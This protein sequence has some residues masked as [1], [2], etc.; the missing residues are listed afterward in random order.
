MQGDPAPSA[1]FPSAPPPL[2]PPATAPPPPVPPDPGAVPPPG[3]NLTAGR[4]PAEVRTKFESMPVMFG[5]LAKGYASV[6][7]LLPCPPHVHLTRAEHPGAG[8]E[9]QV[10]RKGVAL[11]QYN[12]VKQVDGI[13]AGSALLAAQES[14]PQ[15][16][17]IGSCVLEADLP[18][19]AGS[20]AAVEYAAIVN[21]HFAQKINQFGGQTGVVQEHAL[22]A[23]N[24]ACAAVTEVLKDAGRV[25]QEFQE[26][27]E[28]YELDP[29][30]AVRATVHKRT[31]LLVDFEWFAFC[32]NSWGKE[33][34]RTGFSKL[35]S[36]AEQTKQ[37]H[38]FFVKLNEALRKIKPRLIQAAGDGGCITHT[39][40]AGFFEAIIFGISILERR[41]VKHAG[42]EH[43]RARL[44]GLLVPFMSGFAMSYDYGAFDS[45]NC[46]HK[47]DPRHSMKVLIENKI[48]K[49]LFGEDISDSSREALEDRC[50]EFLRSRSAYWLL[51]TKTF[52]RESGDRGTS[53]LNFLVNLILWL[54]IM[55]MESAYRETC[56]KHPAAAAQVP[57][58][59]GNKPSWI[60]A[61]VQGM[62]YD[63][64]IVRKFLRGEPCGFDLIAEGD[65]GLWLFTLKFITNSPGG[66]D[67]LAD[68]IH[69]W[70]CM[71]GMNLE[72]Q[73]E[74]GEA[75]GS[76]R[77]Q[78]VDRRME[79][80]SRIIVPYWSVV[81]EKRTGGAKSART[82]PGGVP[83]PEG[84]REVLRVGLLPKMRK[85]IEAADITFGLVG[86]TVL[87]VKTKRSIAFTKFASAAFNSLDDPFMF[88]YFMMHSRVLLLGDGK[89]P[90][91]DQYWDR[92]VQARFMY[93][94]DNYVHRNML[95][96]LGGQN[97]TR[98][99]ETAV[100]MP[101]GPLKLLQLLRGRHDRALKADGHCA[102]MER[103]VMLESP[104]IDS[105]F[106]HGSIH[107][108]QNASTWATCSEWSGLIKDRL[109]AV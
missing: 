63:D 93:S 10:A 9:S 37:R 30:D 3:S 87:D 105:D 5:T 107:V 59:D 97:E 62:E 45:A 56:K 55:G 99:E 49:E 35:P 64:T 66:A 85:T 81:D 77:V 26:F 32:P 60:N 20:G 34:G 106:Y 23:I 1:G 74:T 29:Q 17:V 42:P 8:R 52:G 79:H 2:P 48:L 92:D 94:A 70:S 69:Y 84:K 76:A 103:A 72:P 27:P 68:R 65:D 108:M 15:Y 11:E 40:D 44:A 104:L 73:D 88:E 7:T 75:V 28:G 22:P 24:G 89:S 80:C 53:C 58:S 67:G 33:R 25:A 43:L 86:G 83:L 82:R 100:Q 14:N 51:Y 4:K 91:L 50:R 36:T 101:F 19:V 6:E 96:V 90:D 13:Y 18:H 109:G 39:F 31:T 71:Q 102:A 41:S 38:T 57:A 61:F 21:R 98:H 47:D 78:P 46:I 12:E 16:M 54:S 95:S